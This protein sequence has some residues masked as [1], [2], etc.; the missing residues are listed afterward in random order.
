MEEF[1]KS[2]RVIFY[3]RCYHYPNKNPFSAEYQTAIT[4]AE[5]LATFLCKL[6]FKRV[7]LVGASYGAFTALVFAVKHPKMVRS[8]VLAE[9]TVHQLIRDIPDGETIYHDFINALKPVAEEFKRDNDK[10]AMS[11]FSGILGRQLD[12]LPTAAVEAIMHNKFLSL[13]EITLEL[14]ISVK[15]KRSSLTNII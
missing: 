2:Y 7:H 5:N 3:S 6:N 14:S 15:N 1:S 9:S 12:K 10:E 13:P 4:E 8:M 11:I